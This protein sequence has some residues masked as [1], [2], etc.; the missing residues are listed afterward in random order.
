MLRLRCNVGINPTALHD[1]NAAFAAAPNLFV[2]VR[3][4]D[5]VVIVI[6]AAVTNTASVRGSQSVVRV[7]RAAVNHCDG[8]SLTLRHRPRSIGANLTVRNCEEQ[9]VAPMQQHHIKSKHA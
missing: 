8:H 4:I 1:G 7:A 5:P 6:K 9:Q 2:V 3:E